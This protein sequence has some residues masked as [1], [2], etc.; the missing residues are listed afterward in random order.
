MAF[1]LKSAEMNSTLFIAGKNFPEK[2]TS[3]FCK[4]HQVS[5]FY[6]RTPAGVPVPELW[7][8]YKGLVSIHPHTMVKGFEAENL[9]DASVSLDLNKINI[10]HQVEPQKHIETRQGKIK[11]QVSDPTGVKF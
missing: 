6:E 3:Q 4:D 7:I 2:I 5:L 8:V 1:K 11:A 9:K 10:P